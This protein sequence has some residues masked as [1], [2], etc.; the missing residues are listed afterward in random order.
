MWLCVGVLVVFAGFVLFVVLFVSWIVCVCGWS[1]GW[2]F[3]VV[4]VCVRVFV[5]VL[6]LSVWFVCL[7]VCPLV[8]LC[9]DMVV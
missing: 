5:C 3:C 7:C 6:S 8:C 4:C 1:C 9:V 2:L